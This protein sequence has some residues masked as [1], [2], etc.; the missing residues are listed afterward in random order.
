M[1]SPQIFDLIAASGGIQKESYHDVAQTSSRQDSASFDATLQHSLAKNTI[2]SRH[3]ATP[4]QAGQRAAKRSAPSSRSQADRSQGKA[5][6]Q[7]VKQDQPD[8]EAATRTE[9]TDTAPVKPEDKLS[10][11]EDA[12]QAETGEATVNPAVAAPQAAVIPVQALVVPEPTTP[13]APAIQPA[14]SIQ[15]TGSAPVVADAVAGPSVATATSGTGQTGDQPLPTAVE[16]QAPVVETKAAEALSQVQAT[17]SAGP[18]D[19]PAAAQPTVKKQAAPPSP[20]PAKVEAKDAPEAQSV[21]ADPT[22]TQTAQPQATT[23]AAQVS[24]PENPEG[25][26]LPQ[27]PDNSQP[28][29][30]AQA[31]QNG[32]PVLAQGQNANTNTNNLAPQQTPAAK[33][34]AGVE[35]VQGSDAPKVTI[36]SEAK[37]PTGPAGKSDDN[38]AAN[39][40]GIK[41]DEVLNS[42]RSSEVTRT[43]ETKAMPGAEVI[44]QIA[45]KTKIELSKGNK[46]ITIR[47]DPP[48]L[49]KVDIKVSS[50]GGVITT[51]FEVT[52]PAVRNLLEANLDSLRSALEKSNLGIGQCTVSLNS[53]NQQG[54]ADPQRFQMAGNNPRSFFNKPAIQP[55]PSYPLASQ[56]RSWAEGLALDYFA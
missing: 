46:E 5:A 53:N 47:L 30:S 3:E 56:R 28:Q 21:K 13:I 38:S 51:R 11:T 27:S 50:E 10:K 34:S 48:H 36:Q 49:G 54:A 14:N 18:V 29:Q 2:S 25:A 24:Q 45:S 15:P 17:G 32:A 7:A 40:Q 9:P 33:Q 22:P 55:E 26:A 20:T 6:K 52:A 19:E 43:A 41:F 23:N 42:T 12:P 44:E 37:E 35:A 8:K 4:H 31:E 39:P 1:N 16:P